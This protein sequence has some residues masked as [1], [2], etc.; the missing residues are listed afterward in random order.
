MEG[1]R[2][3][4][5]EREEAGEKDPQRAGEAGAEERPGEGNLRQLR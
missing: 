4:E 1:Q 5:R 3:R 2:G